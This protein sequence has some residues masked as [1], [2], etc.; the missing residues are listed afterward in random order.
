MYVE[1]KK[2]YKY[3]KHKPLGSHMLIANWF[4]VKFPYFDTR[5]QKKHLNNTKK[6]PAKINKTKYLLELH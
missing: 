2:I 6:N 1:R 5:T 4:V 3:E